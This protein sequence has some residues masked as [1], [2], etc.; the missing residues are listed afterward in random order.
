M[1]YRAKE[2]QCV[3]PKAAIQGSGTVNLGL[4]FVNQPTPEPVMP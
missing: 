4:Q 3:Y 1:D 2:D